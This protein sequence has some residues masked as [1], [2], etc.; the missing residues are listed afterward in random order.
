MELNRALNGLE[1]SWSREIALERIKNGESSDQIIEDFLKS[2]NENIETISNY[3]NDE[4]I[5]FIY[6][7]EELTDCEI[8][9]LKRIRD[10]KKYDVENIKTQSL[11]KKLI[12]KEK[13]LFEIGLFMDKWSNK[14]VIGILITISLISLTKQAWA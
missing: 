1:K 6:Q 3:I 14:L 12:N 8:K 11:E 5:A 4:N 2:N 9:L 10:L 13:K 7:L